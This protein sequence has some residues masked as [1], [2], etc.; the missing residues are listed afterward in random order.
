M[1]AKGSSTGFG[2]DQKGISS[3]RTLT[4]D[5]EVIRKNIDFMLSHFKSQHEL[6]P[7]AILL[8]EQKKWV[9]IN[10]DAEGSNCK[11]QIFS[12]SRQYNFI[13]CRINAFPAKTQHSIDFEVKNMTS[14]S[15]IMLD[16]DLEYFETRQHLD[17]QLSKIIKKLS[18]KF[19][20]DANPT[21]LWTGNGYHIYQPLDGIVFEN[22]QAFYDFL[23][24]L[25]GKDLTTEFM[26]FTEKFFSDGKADP[27]HHPSI[28]NCLL[29]VPGTINSKNGKVVEIIQKWDGNLPN[30]RY[31]ASDFFDYLIDKRNKIIIENKR[32]KE[33]RSNYTLSYNYP[34]NL[35]I[36]RIEW[37]EK[38]LQ[39]PL[40]DHRK[41]CIFHILVP[42]LLNIRKISVEECTKLLDLWVSRCNK[43]R[44]VDFNPSIEIKNRIKYVKDFKPM[45][46][47]KL[48]TVNLELYRLIN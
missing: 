37:I 1:L 18:Q 43:I 24:Y 6:F 7:R 5:N 26:R 48:Q 20:E 9:I 19:K 46:L 31:V 23:P 22:E 39:T 40:S 34:N 41:Y 27:K 35:S 30:I 21:I 16:L 11:D 17:K 29:R 36:R 12:Y 25:D 38:L 42:Y 10:Y 3:K 28:N 45:S 33:L 32:Q 47:S 13:D 8:G 4:V 2:Y 14:A 44:P 15:L